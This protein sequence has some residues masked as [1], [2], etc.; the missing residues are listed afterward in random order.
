[1]SSLAIILSLCT[2][3]AVGIVYFFTDS[4]ILSIIILAL[5]IF[6]ALYLDKKW[7]LDQA[8]MRMKESY[9]RSREQIMKDFNHL[10]NNQSRVQMQQRK[11]MTQAVDNIADIS[12]HI[13][14]DSSIDV[15]FVHQLGLYIPR[16]NKILDTY[17]LKSAD[18]AFKQQSQEFMVHT[19]E[20]FS[21]LL[22]ATGNQDMKEAEVLMQALE[23]TYKS[24]GHS[25]KDDRGELI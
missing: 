18:A 11:T 9:A 21:K 7:R 23:E 14:M 22:T 16:I 25:K 17:L 5:G 8:D 2:V 15:K 20:V 12:H 13:L 3:A 19:S 24:H 6:L 10:K 1:M 4:L